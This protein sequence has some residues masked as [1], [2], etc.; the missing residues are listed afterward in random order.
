MDRNHLQKIS[1]LVK[2]YKLYKKCGQVIVSTE[3]NGYN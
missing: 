3:Y 1:K 2:I